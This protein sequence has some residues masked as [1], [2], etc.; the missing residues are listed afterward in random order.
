MTNL[1]DLLFLPSLELHSKMT[2]TLGWRAIIQSLLFS[3]S[4]INSHYHWHG[5]FILPKQP[6]VNTVLPGRKKLICA[7]PKM[8]ILGEEKIA[9]KL[10]LVLLIVRLT[11]VYCRTCVSQGTP[12][13]HSPAQTDYFLCTSL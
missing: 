8:R 5:S 3:T 11:R 12:S 13:N 4:I 1:Q 2:S 7:N 9:L 6:T 10:Y